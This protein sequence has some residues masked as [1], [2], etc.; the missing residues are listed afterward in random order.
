MKILHRVFSQKN[1]IEGMQTFFCLIL[2]AKIEVYRVK[3]GSWRVRVVS[4]TVENLHKEE[5]F[6]KKFA[7]NSKIFKRC[8]NSFTHGER[9]EGQRTGA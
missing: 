3:A 7:T 2:R 1:F 4:L 5:K 8:R 6:S 9:K